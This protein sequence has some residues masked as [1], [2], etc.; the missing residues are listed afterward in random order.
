MSPVHEGASAAAAPGLRGSSR[1]WFSRRSRRSSPGRLDGCASLEPTAYSPHSSEPVAAPALLPT[2]VF[3][4]PARLRVTHVEMARS[5]EIWREGSEGAMRVA[6]GAGGMPDGTA[7]SSHRMWMWLK[8]LLSSPPLPTHVPCPF[9][10]SK[11]CRPLLAVDSLLP[12]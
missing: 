6:A 7:E 11:H 3:L 5:E 12:D 4:P 10:G 9:A 1:L 8:S 2:C